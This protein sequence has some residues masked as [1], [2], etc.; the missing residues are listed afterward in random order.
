MRTLAILVAGVIAVLAV[1]FA[2]PLPSHAAPAPAPPATTPA[3]K[4][5]GPSVFAL[6]NGAALP[7]NSGV[8][9]PFDCG[10]LYC[11]L[12]KAGWANVFRVMNTKDEEI[13]ALA[14]EVARLKDALERAGPKRCATLE[15]VN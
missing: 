9:T 8:I 6:P 7:P 1:A 3:P 15:R 13:T 4:A 10:D 12:P 14:L 11:T 5:D 2:L